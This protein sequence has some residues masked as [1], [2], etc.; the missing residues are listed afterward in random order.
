MRFHADDFA[1]LNFCYSNLLIMDILVNNISNVA[2][3][4]TGRGLNRRQ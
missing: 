3:I 4:R 2:I 1:F